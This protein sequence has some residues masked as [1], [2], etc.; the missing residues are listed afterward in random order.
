MTLGRYNKVLVAV[1]LVGLLAALTV[2]WQRYQVE[3]ANNQVEMVMDYDEVAELAR[4]E[5]VNQT[6]L[7]RQLKDA[8]ITSLTVSEATM[9]K[10]SKSGRLSV[11]S[12]AMLLQQ[13]RA[14]TLPA[15]S[16]L[17]QLAAAGRIDAAD[18]YI[19]SEQAAV[20]QEVTRDLQE[21]LGPGRL[22]SVAVAP[23]TVLDVKADYEK[24]LK[25]NLG[26][27]TADLQHV[28]SLG[29]YVVPR[30]SNYNRVT[31]DEVN[32]VFDRLA[33]VDKQSLS[34]MMFNGS[35]ALGHPDLLPLVARRLQEDGLTLDMIEHPLQ[36][37]FLKQDGL[38]PLAALTNYQAARVY[39]IGKDEQAKLKIAEAVQ[40]YVVSDRERNVRVNFIHRFDSP[41]PGQTLVQTNL[42]YITLLSQKLLRWGFTLG[43]ASCFAPYFPAP[44]LLVLVIAGAAA[45]GVLLLAQLVRLPAR[46]QYGLWAVTALPLAAAVLHGGGTLARQAAALAGAIAF[47]VLAMTWQ[48]DRWRLRS[49]GPPTLWRV[50]R[51]G[52]AGLVLTFFLSLIGGLYT[53][54]LL[55]DV[56]FLLEI[57][58]YRGVK[59]TFVAPVLLITLIYLE[60]FR[61]FATDRRAASGLWCQVKAV[62]DYPVAVKVLLGGAAAAVALWVFV[63]RSGHT[64]GV[65]VPG[66]ELQ[67]RHFLEEVLY[68]R[69]REKEFLIGHP[70]F[71]L[72]VLALYRRWPRL[73]HYLLVVLATIGQG[74]LVETFSHLRSPVLLSLVRGGDGLALGLVLGIIAVI[75]VDALCRLTYWWG[76]RTAPHV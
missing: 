35:E 23:F 47:P 36:L 40:Q 10:L 43:R 28:A 66:I 48:I 71:L 11:W 58:Y 68:A 6:A 72:A 15:T 12:G 37:G 69:P 7:L 38:L 5:G 65:P 62:L 8:G 61:P 53:A 44:W 64:A 74:S 1:V 13:Y 67:V 54:A 39:T 60:R 41:A 29:F 32:G 70:A 19:T 26:L 22:T 27:P 3:R 9:E 18:V 34:G 75:A 17:G 59:L 24:V 52:T 63:G 45:A 4:L 2:D 14:G 55:G 21:R 56:R 50:L 25:W 16:P 31:P 20:L 42:T 30:P 33:A 57:L 51:D 73:L 76:R 46:W 49:P